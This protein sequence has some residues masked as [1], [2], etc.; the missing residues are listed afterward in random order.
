V[1]FLPVLAALALATFG[2][3][4]ITVTNTTQQGFTAP[5]ETGV[6][7]NPTVAAF[8]YIWYTGQWGTLLDMVPELGEY[9]S[10]NPTVIADHMKWLKQAGFDEIIVSWWGTSN[11]KGTSI[12]ANVAPVLSAAAQNGI[13]V[14]IMIDEYLGRT[15]QSVVNDVHYLIS[16]YGASP[17]WYTTTRDTNN[18]TAG[19]A[20]PVFFV[21]YSGSDTTP[22]PSQWTTAIQ[23]IHSADNAIMLVHYDYDPTWTTTGN[24]DGMFGYG[25]EA[26][27]AARTLAQSL[28]TGAWYVPT[29]MPGF[30]AYRSKGWTGIVDRANGATYQ[31]AWEAALNFGIDAPMFSVTSF[32]EWSE[33]TQIEPCGEGKDTDGFTF[34]DYG[35]VGPTGYLTATAA[36]VPKAHNYVFADYSLDKSVYTVAGNP[37][38]AVGLWQVSWGSVSVSQAVVVGGYYA[39][40]PAS[41]S[42]LLNYQVSQAYGSSTPAS[43]TIRINYFDSGNEFRL[44]V[45][46]TATAT[47]HT[48]SPWIVPGNTNKFRTA[49]FKVPA[50]VF[51]EKFGGDTDFRFETPS[52]GKFYVQLVEVTKN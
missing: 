16:H 32:N 18:L 11:A 31:Q 25:D 40:A 12:D 8:Y 41:G 9:L 50:A 33:T 39:I 13:K 6:H 42:Y 4:Q 23:S 34:Q 28:P 38:S 52:G 30:N 3:G 46:N 51:N 5:T 29:S 14:I 21:Y 24:F 7:H 19:I 48:Y 45:N 49:I 2:F 36:W 27:T 10:D 20:R 1:K 37:S 47:V 17:A 15:P 35:T 44:A 26:L 43:Y 22:A